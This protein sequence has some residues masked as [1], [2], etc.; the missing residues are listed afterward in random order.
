MEL[1]LRMLFIG[2]YTSKH[3]LL[4]QWFNS[5]LQSYLH[6]LYIICS[7]FEPSNPSCE[8][9]YSERSKTKNVQ[10]K[11]EIRPEDMTFWR[12]EAHFENISTAAINQHLH[13]QFASKGISSAYTLFSYYYYYRYMC[14]VLFLSEDTCTS[15]IYW[16]YFKLKAPPVLS[17]IPSKYSVHERVL[18]RSGPGWHFRTTQGLKNLYVQ[19]SSMLKKYLIY[20]CIFKANQKNIDLMRW[21]TE[22]RCESECFFPVFTKCA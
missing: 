18:Y 15:Y 21:R 10:R 6:Y 8:R 11:T 20:I 16:S 22:T 5:I 7:E 2:A 13:S 17:S 9:I 4:I 3:F 14:F 12:D 1:I 19:Q